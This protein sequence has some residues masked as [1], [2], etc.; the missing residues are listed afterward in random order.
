MDRRDI[1]LIEGGW[2]VFFDEAFFDEVVVLAAI[3]GDIDDYH[4]LI[5]VG[6]GIK[7]YAA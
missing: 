6:D 7:Q 4:I 5:R 2:V 3:D 1:E